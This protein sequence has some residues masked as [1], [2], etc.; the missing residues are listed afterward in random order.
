MASIL[1]I[2]QI[3]ISLLLIGSILIQARGAGLSAAFGG[4]STFYHTRRGLERII[5]WI[6]IVLSA[7][8]V[9]VNI[10]SFVL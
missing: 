4:E 3:V 10:A 7:L 5:L 8:F 9:A 6:T 1:P 2:A